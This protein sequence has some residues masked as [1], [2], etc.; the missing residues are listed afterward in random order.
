[1]NQGDAHHGKVTQCDMRD[2][3]GAPLQHDQMSPPQAPPFVGRQDDL[4]TLSRLLDQ[5]R[6]GMGGALV[7]TGEPGIGKTRLLQHR[8][9]CA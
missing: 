7:L 6:A 2:H 8:L 3:H 5:L 9:C 1:M 4:G